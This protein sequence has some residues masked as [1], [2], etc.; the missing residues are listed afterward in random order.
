MISFITW[1]LISL[2]VA[3]IVVNIFLGHENDF[4]GP[5]ARRLFSGTLPQALR[6][7]TSLLYGSAL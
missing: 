6:C 5:A 4:G 1:T 2:L 3:I 7:P